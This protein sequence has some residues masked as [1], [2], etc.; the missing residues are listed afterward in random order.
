MPG[1]MMQPAA[2]SV[3]DHAHGPLKR[4]SGAL[5][6]PGSHCAD[7]SRVS[8]FYRFLIRCLPAMLLLGFS[9]PSSAAALRVKS[10]MTDVVTG[11]TVTLQLTLENFSKK[12]I[13]NVPKGPW[14]DIDDKPFSRMS[15]TSIVNFHKTQSLVLSYNM[16]ILKAEDFTLPP[17]TAF[18]GKKSLSSNRLTFHVRSPHR[19]TGAPAAPGN[20]CMARIDRD[21]IYLGEQVIYTVELYHESRL[22]SNKE[23]DYPNFS[24]FKA[25]RLGD[26]QSGTRNISGIPH[27]YRRVDIILIPQKNGHFVIS[28]P[29]WIIGTGGFWG[30]NYALRGNAVAITVK[31][32]PTEG[33]PA[34]FSGLAGTWNLHA[35]V[36]KT[37]LPSGE[38]LTLTLIA[39]G[40]G[41]P[42]AVMA[43]DLN[44]I[45][46]FQVYRP[47]SESKKEFLNNRL[48][49]T[50]TFRYLLV[51]EHPGML[52]IPPVHLD[53]F[54]TK[55]GKYARASTRLIR[56]NVTQGKS[57]ATI[58]D[59]KSPGH[60]FKVGSEI[61]FIKQSVPLLK[62]VARF[63]SGW[64][65]AVLVIFPP[66]LLLVTHAA[67]RRIERLQTDSGYARLHGASKIVRR[68]LKVAGHAAKAMDAQKL[69][70]ETARAVTGFIADRL[71]IPASRILASKVRA[72]LVN[73]GVS[74][75]LAED[76]ETLLKEIDMRRF[77]PG[78]VSAEKCRQ[79]LDSAR[80]VLSGLEKVL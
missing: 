4:K 41:E 27:V 56:I 57:D 30:Q 16:R 62:P 69:D 68:R 74:E 35:K 39:S 44:F 6:G 26:P 25:M 38:T 58:P 42:G 55:N 20:H 45:R 79:V 18:D 76:T 63:L 8:L 54:D 46:G 49:T 32:L 37:S 36:D 78:E 21:V 13:V 51:P 22:A 66:V 23:P 71:D 12:A 64:L 52:T 29:Q 53:Y 34:D 75:T 33:R 19:V 47:E 2:I 10:D 17:F 65:V 9:L 70:E 50:K 24:D 7:D 77:A 48:F 1:A 43:P 40:T 5:T 67:M 59:M 11:D 14:F 60:G 80:K 15:Q 28:R 73:A 31:P 3:H 61:R 72:I